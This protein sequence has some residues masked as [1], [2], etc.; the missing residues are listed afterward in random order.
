MM[1]PTG[2]EKLKPLLGKKRKNRKQTGY[3]R[4]LT[5]NKTI[6]HFSISN[7][8]LYAIFLSS[9]LI[10]DRI[11]ILINFIPQNSIHPLKFIKPF[12]SIHSLFHLPDDE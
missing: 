2:K 6:S 8:Q 11:A 10:Q 3:P 5:Y 1:K 9:Y 12:I 4:T 7:I